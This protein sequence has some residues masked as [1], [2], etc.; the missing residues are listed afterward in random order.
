MSAVRTEED[1]LGEV[2]IPDTALWGIQTAR[3]V[4]NLSFSGRTLG[5]CPAYVR[6]LGLVKRAAARAN[7]DA[8]VL[9]AP[10][11]E[12]IETATGP[13]IA[14]ALPDQFPVDLLGGGGSIGVNMNV[15]EVIANLA[16]ERLGEQRGGYVPVHPLAHVNA[17]QSTADVCHTAL[18]LAILE[19]AALLDGA[20]RATELTLADQ[21]TAFATIPTLAR[22]C[23]RDALP[24]TVD[25]LF[26]GHAALLARRAAAVRQALMPLSAISLGGTV[27]GTG[28]GAPAAYRAAVVPLLAEVCERVLTARADGP[29]A[30]QNS[31]DIAALSAQLA[32]LAQAVL[33]IAQDL[34]LLAS[35]PQGGFGELVLLNVQAGSSIF[36]GKVN[37]VVPETVIQCAFQV[38]GCD[39][40][41]QAAVEHAELHVNVFDGLAA[42]N[43]LGAIDMLAGA[44]GRFEAQCLRGLAVD[45]ARCRALAAFGQLL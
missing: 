43:V 44:L 10:L 42:A 34:R 18:R 4:A 29:D 25:V 6:A 15:N 3:A 13:L 22:T 19:R 11:A 5:S 24:T 37:P 23:L 8:G 12:A 9:T 33:K 20:L 26:G 32:L 17:S 7:R 1:A 45:E 40:A 35:G 38:F 16:N 31:D 14:A 30:L 21:A 2:E 41:V 36:S 39:R 27:I 28:D